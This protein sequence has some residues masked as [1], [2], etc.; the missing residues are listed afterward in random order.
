MERFVTKRAVL[1]PSV[2]SVAPQSFMRIAFWRVDSHFRLEWV[3]RM[4]ASVA[5]S[6]LH[7]EKAVLISILHFISHNVVEAKTEGRCGYKSNQIS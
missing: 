5:C 6:S 2:L 7:I 1:L 3:W 4:D